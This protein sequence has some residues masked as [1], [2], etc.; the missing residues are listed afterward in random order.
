MIISLHFLIF[1]FIQK[2]P[3]PV[4]LLEINMENNFTIQPSGLF[5]FVCTAHFRMLFKVTLSYSS[6]TN[7]REDKTAIKIT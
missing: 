2:E 6:I 4:C 3:V 5:F 7:R 1:F